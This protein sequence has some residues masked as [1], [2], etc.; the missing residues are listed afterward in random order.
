MCN[1]KAVIGAITH[2]FSFTIII[3]FSY[4]KGQQQHIGHAKRMQ[5]KTLMQRLQ[6]NRNILWEISLNKEDYEKSRVTDLS[7]HNKISKIEMGQVNKT[8]ETLQSPT[9]NLNTAA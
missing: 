6:K 7:Y 1:F 2:S 3:V 4:Q 8:N 9:L 5:K